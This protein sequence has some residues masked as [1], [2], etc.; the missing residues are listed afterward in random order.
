MN[1]LRLHLLS[2][3]V[4]IAAF[5]S[6]SVNA[7]TLIDN[8]Y[9]EFDSGTGTARV[10][11][12]PYMSSTDIGRVIIPP[13]V[14]YLTSTYTVTEVSASAFYGLYGLTEVIFPETM[15]KIGEKAFQNC[16]GLTA[17]TFPASVKEI[18]SGAFSGCNM[19]SVVCEAPNPPLA[20]GS[21]NPFSEETLRYAVLSVPKGSVDSYK[22]AAGWNRFNKVRYIGQVDPTGITMQSAIEMNVE[23]TY[24]LQAI[25]SPSNVTETDIIWSSSNPAIVSVNNSGTITAKETGTAKITATTTNG[26]TASCAVTVVRPVSSIDIAEESEMHVGDSRKLNVTVNPSNAT[27][28]TL[29]FR[30]SNEGVIAVSQDGLVTANALGSSTITVTANSGVSATV[31]LTVVPTPVTSISLP[32][33][34][35]VYIGESTSLE[36]IIYPTDATYKTLTWSS[37]NTAVVRVDS[38][39]KITGI[40]AGN[41]DVT[42]TAHNGIKATVHVSVVPVEVTSIELSESDLHLAVG[43]SASLTAVVKPQNAT[44]KT[45][46]WESSNEEVATVNS[47]GKVT[48]VGVGYAVITARTS[49]GLSASCSVEADIPVTSLNIDFDAMGLP[50]QTAKLKAT[51]QLEIKVVINPEDATDKTLTFASTDPSKASVDASG[52]VTA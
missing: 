13:T 40:A 2:I 49:N 5:H 19:T 48:A 23:S 47:A 41:A 42:A 10:V 1:K 9:Y 8:L 3:L 52:V 21:V 30:S 4:F 20:G 25:L 22:A 32:S 39:G 17:I 45:V 11:R 33:S 36:A 51:E 7:I 35:T 18:V 37:S 14:K 16:S 50:D 28:K 38:S 12:T 15:Q 43:K 34:S 6:A 29:L 26:L 44:D 46:T 24:T 31:R 27:D